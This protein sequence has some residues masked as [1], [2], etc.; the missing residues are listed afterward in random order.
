MSC[1]TSLES[2][3]CKLGSG[4][5]RKGTGVVKK[6]LNLNCDNV[7]AF[8]TTSSC[9]VVLFL[10][11]LMIHEGDPSTVEEGTKMQDCTEASLDIGTH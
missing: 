5:F 7:V 11:G 6:F 2:A 3:Q 10:C 1:H 8:P 9:G 4:E